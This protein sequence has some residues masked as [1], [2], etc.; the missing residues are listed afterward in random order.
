MQNAI[1]I[2]IL[3]HIIGGEPAQPEVKICTSN[4]LTEFQK[5]GRKDKNPIGS[6]LRYLCIYLEMPVVIKDCT[7]KLDH[8]LEI[9]KM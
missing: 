1:I 7:I 6:I 3:D 5:G 9:T 8:E 4:E 2:L